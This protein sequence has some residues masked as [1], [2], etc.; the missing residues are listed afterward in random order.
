MGEGVTVTSVLKSV[1]NGLGFVLRFIS[2]I[3]K[4]I[5]RVFLV[6][7]RA[8]KKV[9]SSIFDL[10]KT[11]GTLDFILKAYHVFYSG[12]ISGFVFIREAATNILS[13]VGDLLAGIFSGDVNQIKKG[14]EGLDTAFSDAGKSSAKAFDTSF[15]TKHKDFFVGTGS[16]DDPLKIDSLSKYLDDGSVGAKGTGAGAKKSSTSVDGV[17]SGRPTH[18]NIDI[19]KLIENFVVKSDTIEDMENKVKEMVS[20]ALVSAVNDVNLVAG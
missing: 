4:T 18:I 15:N 10:A 11:T 16:K 20:G 1:F 5:A 7:F 9:V 14:L 19:G 17:S 12:I 6:T 2:P 3:L 8:I 13:G